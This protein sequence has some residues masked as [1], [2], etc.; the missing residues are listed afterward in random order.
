MHIKLIAIPSSRHGNKPALELP[1]Q[2]LGA[3]LH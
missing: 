2:A 1:D 3:Y